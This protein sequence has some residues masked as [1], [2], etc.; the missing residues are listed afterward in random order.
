MKKWDSRTVDQERSTFNVAYFHWTLP[1]YSITAKISLERGFWN[2]F[3]TAWGC[4]FTVVLISYI[5]YHLSL[6]LSWLISSYS[7]YSS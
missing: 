3:E 1:P 6:P 4:L 2:K 7:S 5:I